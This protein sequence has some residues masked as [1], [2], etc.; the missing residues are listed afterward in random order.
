MLT[1]VSG[2][3]VKIA[4]EEDVRINLMRGLSSRPAAR[5]N[6]TGQDA[7]YLSSN[8]AS[9]RVAIGQYVGADDRPRVLLTYEVTPCVLYDLRDPLSAE[10][11]ALARQPW[12]SALSA[13]EVPPSWVAADHV[14]ASGHVG[15]IDPSRQSPGLWHIALFRWNDVEAP[16]VKLIGD[17]KPISVTQ[18]PQHT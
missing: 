17:P 9:A 1:E 11:Y 5:F 13:G 14:R 16:T 15:L 7:L 12:Q 18:A 6:R 4:F 2:T 10:I 8:E 3:F